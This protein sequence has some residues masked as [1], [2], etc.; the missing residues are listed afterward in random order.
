M[1]VRIASGKADKNFAWLHLSRI[2]AMPV[3]TTTADF[4]E[5]AARYRYVVNELI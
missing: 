1:P 4:S 2:Q 5:Y 3:M